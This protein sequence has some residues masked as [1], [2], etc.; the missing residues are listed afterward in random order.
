MTTDQT[1][2]GVAREL[3]ERILSYQWFPSGGVLTFDRRRIDRERL[4]ALL[5]VERCTCCDGSGDLIDLTGEWRGYCVCPAG[6]ALKNKPATQPQ[7][8]PTASSSAVIGHIEQRRSMGLAIGS[9]I[10]NVVWEL[11]HPELQ[12][13]PDGAKLY[14]H[15]ADQPQGEP[16][17]W[18]IHWTDNGEFYFTLRNQGRLWKY[19]QDPDFKVVPLYAEQPAPIAVV[20]PSVAYTHTEHCDTR[21]NAGWNACLDEV[22]RLNP[23]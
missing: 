23:R 12:H 20:L 13:L 5:E 18:D 2:D 4:S 10:T 16:V 21:F 1:I 22:T 15:P 8:E 11:P 14:L 6:V 17:A 7:G 3:L 19:E 9:P